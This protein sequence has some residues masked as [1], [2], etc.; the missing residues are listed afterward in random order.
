MTRTLE[1][2]AISFEYEPQTPVLRGVT[3]GVTSGELLGVVGPNGSGKSTLLRLLCGLMRPRSGSVRLDGKPL[4]AFSTLQRARVIA[5]LPQLVNPVFSL[6][7]FE[8]VCLGRHPHLGAL[9]ALGPRDRDVAEHCLI[10]TGI[11]YLRD[12]DFMSLS[13]GERQR[14]LVASILAQEPDLM[15]LDEPTSALDVHHQVEVFALL[16]RLAHSG[17]GVAAVTHDVNL[18]ARFCDRLLLLGGRDHEIV[19]VGPPV[20]VLTDELLSRAYGAAIRVAEHPLTGTPLVT[21]DA[22]ERPGP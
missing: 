5:F 17:Y 22:P 13:G 2:N 16:R 11:E 18:A 9:G 3:A 8:V 20:A 12:R 15:L 6:K 10:D 7:V 14:V 21:A 19:A 4:A 1:A